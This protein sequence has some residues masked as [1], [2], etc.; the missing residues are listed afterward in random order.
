ML[1]LFIWICSKAKETYYN[2]LYISFVALDT[3]LLIS[4]YN[5]IYVK[6]GLFYNDLKNVTSL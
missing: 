5:L 3:V 6:E 2:F 1:N 4:N